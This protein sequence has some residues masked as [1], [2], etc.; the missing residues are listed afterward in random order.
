MLL[1]Q[2]QPSQCRRGSPNQANT[3]IKSPLFQSLLDR[4]KAT[5]KDKQDPEEI[6]NDLCNLVMNIFLPVDGQADTLRNVLDKVLNND[7]DDSVLQ[8]ELNQSNQ[9][10][11][12]V[13]ETVEINQ[14]FN[15][16]FSKLELLLS[17]INGKQDTEK[18]APK[19]LLLLQQWAD[20]GKPS[21]T[22]KKIEQAIVIK[23]D[24]DMRNEK[25]VKELIQAFHK[26]EQ[27][28]I[29]QKYHTLAKVTTKDVAKWIHTALAN[30]T[31]SDQVNKH[32]PVTNLT[33]PMPKSGQWMIHIKENHSISPDKQLLEQFKTL[34][35]SSVFLTKPNG[36]SQLS[37]TLK[38]HNLG[39]MLVHLT[40]VDGKMTVKIV[41]NTHATK[42]MLESNMHQL[43]T[44][45]SPNQVVIE[46]QDLLLRQ[47]LGTEREQNNQQSKNPKQ[48]Q[49]DQSKQNEPENTDAANDFPAQFHELLMN[50][51]V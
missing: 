1:H 40:E 50:E 34:L 43:R 45:F 13:V 32:S 3:E 15:E 7:S 22:L 38:P 33:L 37:L 12:D 14:Q 31:Q 25:V 6:Q 8:L 9:E 49:S 28:A 27:L 4:N 39:E 20:Q 29:K 24:E 11:F 35:N 48:N 16:M 51:K 42:E 18:T 21:A 19:I 36:R 44:M 2:V 30:H 23:D 26:R 10:Q 46:K 47:D 17:Q 5:I 41:V